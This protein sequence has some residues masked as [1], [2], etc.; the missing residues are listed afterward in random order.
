MVWKVQKIREVDYGCE[1]RQPGESLKVLV[2]LENEQGEERRILEE[3]E[4]LYENQIEEGSLWP[5]KESKVNFF[6]IRKP[7]IWTKGESCRIVSI[8]WESGKI[9]IT[10]E[11]S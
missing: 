7:E 5:K 11:R 8:G 6:S 2:I 10:D 1:E 4:W 9:S 3:D